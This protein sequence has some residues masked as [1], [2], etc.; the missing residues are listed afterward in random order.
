[1]SNASKENLSLGRL[2]K[3]FQFQKVYRQGKSLSTPT[4]I[5]FYKKNG[6]KKNYLGISISKKIGNSVQRHRLKRVYREAFLKLKGEVKEGYDFIIVARRGTRQI[7]FHDA[8]ND[9]WKIL[10]RGKLIK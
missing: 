5:L 7:S 10:S 6:A 2:K 1:M 4:T 3:N 9:L 8:V